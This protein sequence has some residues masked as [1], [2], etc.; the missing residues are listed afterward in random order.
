MY[1][2][3]SLRMAF[4][5]L[6]GV[7]VP[8][9]LPTPAFAQTPQNINEFA[10]HIAAIA[11]LP[12]PR[13]VIVAPLEGCLLDED[14]CSAF[15]AAVK[16][17]LEKMLPS[18]RFVDR[19]EVIA[20]VKKFGFLG[21]DIYNSGVLTKTATETGADVH[22]TETLKW[23]ADGDDLAAEV[24]DVRKADSL[25]Q[26]SLKVQRSTP[27]SGDDPVIIRD[28]DTGISLV[29]KKGET[30]GSSLFKYP[31]CI[32]CPD[33]KYSENAR[34]GKIQGTVQLLF[35]LTE[36][37]VPQD[38]RVAKAL[39]PG[40]DASAVE[41]VRKWQLSPAIGFDGKPFAVRMHTEIT[42]RLI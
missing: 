39:E 11:D 27:D 9:P 33:P 26:L 12:R 19:E 34:K 5:L 4:V 42:F 14:I 18:V 16:A 40:L 21:L 30:F 38:I 28:S 41:V 29:V 6:I 3:C 20:T 23:A 31:R 2:N 35:T 13:R 10:E 25:I 1:C 22:V 8:C 37:G 15:E 36:K 17:R 24:L 7:A 32:D